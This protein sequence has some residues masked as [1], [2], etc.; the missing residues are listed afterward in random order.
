MAQVA[1]AGPGPGV[2]GSLLSLFLLILCN[3]EAR[4]RT[5][6]I[7]CTL[8]LRTRRGVSSHHRI[9][10]YLRNILC[11]HVSKRFSL[12]TKDVHL[13]V[14]TL[15]HITVLVETSACIIQWENAENP[16]NK[17]K[18]RFGNL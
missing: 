13:F 5:K 12:K 2:G 17:K 11:K 7:L 8:T 18:K 15:S 6:Y 16:K 9:K 10:T 14:Y 3:P 1:G 4:S